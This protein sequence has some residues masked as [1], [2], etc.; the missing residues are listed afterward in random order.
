MAGVILHKRPEKA[1]MASDDRRLPERAVAI[2]T[3]IEV[4]VRV[5][6]IW[7]MRE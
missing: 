7:N 3:C 5:I 6:I 4:G 1:K 2:F